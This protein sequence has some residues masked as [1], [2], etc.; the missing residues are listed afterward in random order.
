MILRCL[1][2]SERIDK[3]NNK[4]GQPVVQPT[5]CV[6]DQ[7]QAREARCGMILEYQLKGE[8]V[9]NYGGGKL[10][11]KVVSIGIQKIAS[12]GTTLRISGFIMP[13]AK[14]A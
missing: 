14:K 2:N 4:A 6:L 11:D 13:E 3:F 9:A 8:E 5:L 12:F 10:L 1:V 7:D